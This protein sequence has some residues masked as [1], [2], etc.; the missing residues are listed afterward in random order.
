METV[1][2]ED[3][4]FDLVVTVLG[5]ASFPLL[6]YAIGDVTDEPLGMPSTG[7]AILSNVA[8]RHDDLV[9]SRTGRPVLANWLMDIRLP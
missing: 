8:G 4:R 1:P 6:R 9:I 2:R 3:G 5:N 7:F